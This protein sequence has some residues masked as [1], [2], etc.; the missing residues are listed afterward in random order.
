[1]TVTDHLGRELTL[2]N[3]PP[4]RVVS[5]CPS[6]TE[7]LFE[8][9]LGSSVVGRSNWCI[10][11]ALEVKT[12]A[13]VGG[14]KKVNMR[15]VRELA[16]DFFLAEKEENTREMVEELSKIAPVYVTDV[17]SVGDGLRMIRDLGLLF[18]CQPRADTLAMKAEMAFNAIIPNQT[19]LKVVYLIWRDPYML[20]G[21]DTFIQDVLHRMGLN[22]LGLQLSGRY[23]AVTTDQL[24]AFAP[25]IVMLSSE[26]YDFQQQHI[27]ELTT[28]LPN[29]TFHLVDG[30]AFSWYGAR[31]I[32]A[33]AYLGD[34]AGSL[35]KGIR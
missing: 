29:T 31:M 34:L 35:G 7:T 10:H 27:A 8:L 18:D 30:E 32:H 3:Y 15:R 16:P 1:M 20:A 19:N 24:V 23:P 6:Q 5:L 2:E 21:A 22:N 28:F 33:A 4:R 12:V 14:T 26:P 13:S 11:P 25:E 17:R 9:G